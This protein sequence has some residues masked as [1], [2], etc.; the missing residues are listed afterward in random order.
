MKI[1][2]AKIKY[3]EAIEKA[4]KNPG[5]WQLYREYKG[6]SSLQSSRKMNPAKVEG[7]IQGLWFGVD[8]ADNNLYVRYDG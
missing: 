6:S 5:E 1:P 4:I 2:R 8:E 3:T 7:D